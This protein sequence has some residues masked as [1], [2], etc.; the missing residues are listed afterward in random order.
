WDVLEALA[1]VRLDA[2]QPSIVVLPFAAGAGDPEEEYFGDGLADEIIVTLAQVTEIRV[3]A[4]T[5]AF[6]FKGQSI[7]V[8][9]IA[10]LLGVEYVLEGTVRKAGQRVRVTTQLL[11]AS[12]GSPVW[13]QRYDRD[14]PD[15]FHVQEEIAVAISE[16]LRVNFDTSRTRTPAPVP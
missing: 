14:A 9:R 7:D 5:S 11:S 12:N 3:I 8:R 1:R 16:S 15:V 2:A 6:A 10:A 13:S 4:R